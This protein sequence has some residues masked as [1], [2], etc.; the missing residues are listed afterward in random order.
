M[1]APRRNIFCVG[2][3]YRAHASEFAAQRLRRSAQLAA[4]RIPDHPIIFT[5]VPEM[6]DRPGDDDPHPDGVSTAIDYEAELAVVI[7]RGGSGIPASR[8]LEHVWGY[9][10]VNDVTARDLQAPPPAV[11]ARQVARHVL[12]DGP[13]A[14]QRRRARRHAHPRALLGQ[15][16][17][18][19]G[20]QHRAT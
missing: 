11:A 16:R 4:G 5:K 9:T 20:R 17:A 8:A 7:G 10:I 6:R 15:R 13:V 2:M 12:P 14:G 18:A 3:N 19:P 1:P